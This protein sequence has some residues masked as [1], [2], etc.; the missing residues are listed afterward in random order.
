MSEGRRSKICP[1][2]HRPFPP[3]LAVHGPVRQR[4]VDLIAGRPDGITRRELLDLVYA[5][6]P[7]GGP[8]TENVISVLVKKANDDLVFLGYH[9]TSTGGPGS[10][11]RLQRRSA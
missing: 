5:D 7:N 3:A 4:I 8:A 10:R 1:Q 11:Y 9:I 6:D 2:C